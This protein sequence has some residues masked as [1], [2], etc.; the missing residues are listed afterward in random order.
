MADEIKLTPEEE[1]VSRQIVLG[2]GFVYDIYN[3]MNR[4]F[5]LIAQ[6]LNRSEAGLGHI[7]EKSPFTLPRLKKFDTTP[8]N[9]LM[10]TEMGF[11]TT[12]GA[13]QKAVEDEDEDGDEDE[14]ENEAPTKK[15]RKKIDI[16]A[17]DK[18][19]AV[20]AT[21][22]DPKIAKGKMSSFRPTVV[23]VVLSSLSLKPSRKTA[24]TEGSSKLASFKTAGGSLK[25]LVRECRPDVKK[26]TRL[27]CTVQGGELSAA[28]ENVE[29]R[30]VASF[31]SE[32]AVTKFVEQ[33]I[34]MTKAACP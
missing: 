22:Y 18:F 25:K 2:M 21:L 14:D 3:E 30:W 12:I 16:G 26:A 10:K 5:S 9:K 11:L 19:L 7:K 1:E 17:D 24:K 6:L 33:L 32:Q 34:V 27:S 4:L 20:R 8:A 15:R 31:D 29:I 13:D 28:V 23:A